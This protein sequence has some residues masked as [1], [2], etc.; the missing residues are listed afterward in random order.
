MFSRIRE[1][2]RVPLDRPRGAARDQPLI[3]EIK[4]H[5]WNLLEEEVRSSLS[6]R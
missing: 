3:G 2:I 1:D 4:N 6:I 5:I